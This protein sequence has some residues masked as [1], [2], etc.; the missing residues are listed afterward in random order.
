[1][2]K[3][4]PYT[5]NHA[6]VYKNPAVRVTVT[7]SEGGRGDFDLYIHTTNIPK[8]FKI[9]MFKKTHFTSYYLG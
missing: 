9:S 7:E 4:R 1:M 6:N 2:K 3:N 8:Y 5:K